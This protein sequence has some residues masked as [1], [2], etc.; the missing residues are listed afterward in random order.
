METG[1]AA[2]YAYYVG[3]M[4]NYFDKACIKQMLGALV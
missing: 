3:V 4:N 2:G 1:W